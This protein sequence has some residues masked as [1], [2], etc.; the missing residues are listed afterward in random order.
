VDRLDA[1]NEVVVARVSCEG[2]GPAGRE[3][4]ASEIRAA[5]ATLSS[6]ACD[7]RSGGMGEN[8]IVC[9]VTGKEVGIRG[10]ARFN[11]SQIWILNCR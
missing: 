9:Q 10:A 5:M 11:N 8:D 4:I 7:A 2:N 1:S 3:E 6:G